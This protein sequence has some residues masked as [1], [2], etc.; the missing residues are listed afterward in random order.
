[1]NENATQNN[2]N[3]NGREIVNKTVVNGN[4]AWHVEICNS[5]TGRGHQQRRAQRDQQKRSRHVTVE[6]GKM[7]QSRTTQWQK[8]ATVAPPTPA[9]TEKIDKRRT[10]TAEIQEREQKR[11]ENKN[12]RLRTER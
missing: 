11:R 3:R 2:E 7:L 10:V 1:M 6:R 12:G 5:G 8:E 4:A 9:T